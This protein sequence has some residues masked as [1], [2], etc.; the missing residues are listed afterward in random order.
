MLAWSD[1]SKSVYLRTFFYFRAF[2]SQTLLAVNSHVRR[3]R[4]QPAQAM[5]IQ[6]HSGRAAAWGRFAWLDG[7]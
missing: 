7:G 1:K 2:T 6:V 5:A 3:H 4:A